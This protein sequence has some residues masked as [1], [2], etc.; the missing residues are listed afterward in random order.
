MRSEALLALAALCLTP[1]ARAEDPPV[2]AARASLPLEEV[3]RLVRE[4][5]RA[6]EPRPAAAPVGAAVSRLLLAGRLLEDAVD[7]SA[8]VE[9]AVLAEEAWTRVPLLR[10]SPQLHLSALPTVEGGELLV[11]RGE[12]VFLTRTPGRYAFDLGLLLLA[13]VEGD[14][15][16]AELGVAGAALARLDL[17]WDEGLFRLLGDGARRG[18]EGAA[19]FPSG[20]R[21][22]VRWAARAPRALSRAAAEPAERPPVESVITAAHASSVTTLEGRRLTR[23]QYQLRFEGRKPLS[24]RLP[25]GATVE[26]V[27]LNGASVPFALAD[28][29]LA[30]EVAP[31]RVGDQSGR[32]ELVLSDQP[33]AFHLS[34]RLALGLPAASW[35]LDELEVSLHL[36]P[37]FDYAWAGGS[38]AL[39]EGQDAAEVAWDHSLPTPGKVLRFRQSLVSSAPDVAVRYTVALEGQYYRGGPAPAA[40]W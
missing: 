32:L 5:E 13:R 7:L 30:L 20:D 27:Y 40:H 38:L 23:I 28:G 34:G 35:Q 2:A 10:L 14:A 16:V 12:L 22:R 8:H 4:N 1:A 36:P 6:R 3:L 31:P 21:L 18:S 19:L 39:D 11:D 29:T 37:V 17:A 15:R 33:G 9:L 25:P 26:K 24:F